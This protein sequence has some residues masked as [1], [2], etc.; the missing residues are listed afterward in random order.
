MNANDMFQINGSRTGKTLTA[1]GFRLPSVT[2][3]FGYRHRL[4]EGLSAVF[5]LSDIF[6]S[7]RERTVID[8]P[9]LRDLIKRRRAVRTA[10]LA[11]IWTPGGGKKNT[12]DARFDYSGDKD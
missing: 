6:D 11:L 12:A 8:T 10:T 4:R 2:A 5:T 9:G 1:Q 3:N 7:L